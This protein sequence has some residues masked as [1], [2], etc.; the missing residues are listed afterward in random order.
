M[1]KLMRKQ[2]DTTRINFRI[3]VPQVRVID[4]DG[5]QLGVMD[6]RK[7][8]EL[9]KS[10]GLDLAEVS[11]KAVPPVCKILD[12]GKFKYQQKKKAKVAKKKQ[13][14]V[15][16]KEVKLRPQTDLHD[17]EYKVKHMQEFLGEGNKVKVSVRF[18]GREASHAELGHV[19]LKQV[20]DMVGNLGIVEQ[21]ARMEGRVLSIMIAPNPKAK[22]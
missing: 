16:L 18:R 15:L 9:A 7:A 19:V 14:V 8:I 6:T 3:R 1:H 12:F 20:I 4:D 21:D 13:S 2:E 10:K 22:K 17:I 11:P 5:A